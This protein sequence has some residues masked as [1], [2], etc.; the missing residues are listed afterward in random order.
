LDRSSDVAF[1]LPPVEAPD[2]SLRTITTEPSFFV[3]PAGH[4][5]ARR[6]QISLVEVAGLA[7]VAADVASDGCHPTAWR[8][9][10]LINPRPGGDQVTIGAVGRTVEE[11]REQIIAG[12]GIMLCPASAATYHSRPELAFVQ[13]EGV[14]AVELSLAWR[15]DDLNPAVL[16]FLDYVTHLAPTST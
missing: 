12:R 13:A 16:A 15:A 5:L 7:W 8:D 10:W 14:P 6:D 2:I 9:Y 11:F 4:N 1:V 3:L